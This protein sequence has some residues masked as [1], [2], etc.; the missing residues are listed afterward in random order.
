[1][2]RGRVVVVGGGGHARVLIGA[3]K[4]AGYDAE[5]VY[6]DDPATW[7]KEVLGARVV[8]PIS[9]LS[10]GDVRPGL[11]AIGDCATRKAIAGRLGLSW[12]TLVHPR[13]YLD[14]DA[15]AGAGAVVCAGAVVQ[16]GA[17]LGAHVIVNT[18]ATVDHDCAV[19]DF[20]HIAPGA[21]LGG[22][23][24]VGTGA[25]VGIGAAV[26]PGVAVG[27]WSVIGAGGVVVR[28][29]P[30]GVIAYGAPARPMRRRREDE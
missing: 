21:H 7:G 16:P 3:L 6:D 19:G 15:R 30:A 11:L 12:V 26:A 2:T 24:R 27:D 4:A 18:G 10:A 14:P 8:G 28:D 22:A 17:G 23:V 25:M 1:M 9:S 13:A 5:A 29:I 20:A